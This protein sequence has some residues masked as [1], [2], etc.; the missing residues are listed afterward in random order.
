[1]F[2]NENASK[3]ESE[4]PEGKYQTASRRLVTV[5]WGSWSKLR[6]APEFHLSVRSSIPLLFSLFLSLSSWPK[7]YDAPPPA[8]IPAG[9][10]SRP[11][12][13]Y[14]TYLLRT[15]TV[16]DIDLCSITTYREVYIRE[17]FPRKC[18]GGQKRVTNGI[19]KKK[20]IRTQ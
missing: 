17:T 5:N 13:S 8:V 16:F 10:H 7:D 14:P 3:K 18:I 1:M 15:V 6:L 19:R 2:K 11:L 4:V 9:I 20:K 12:Q